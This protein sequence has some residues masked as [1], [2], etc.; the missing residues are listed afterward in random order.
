VENL[1]EAFG[2]ALRL[3]LSGDPVV[4]EITLRTLAISASATAISCL[5]FIPAG[6]FIHFSSFPG[7]GAVIAVIQAFYSVPTVFVGLVIYLM[8]SRSGP[9]GSLEMLFT[10]QGIVLAEVALIAP[11]M[12]GLVISALRGVA[13]EARDTVRALGAGPVKA[14]AVVASEARFALLSTVLVGF[15]RAI[16]EVGAAMMIGGNIAGRTRTLTT[17]ISLGIGK[18]ETAESI[19]LGLILITL[20]LVVS[21]SVHILGRRRK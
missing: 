16:S 2:I 1:A 10:P 18:G 4:M 5:L 9:L 13:P 14:A 17:A 6:S 15:G 20:A 7:K 3:I 11:I 19:A 21:L 12:L 8:I